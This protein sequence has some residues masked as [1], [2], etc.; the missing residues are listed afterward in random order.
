MAAELTIHIRDRSVAAAT[1]GS[2]ATAIRALPDPASALAPEQLAEALAEALSAGDA[3]RRAATLVIPSSWCYVHRVSVPRR[4]P[5]QQVL[6]YALEEFLPV[7]IE[8]L[9]CV[10]IPAAEGGHLGIAVETERLQ[11]LLEACGAHGIH[12]EHVTLD[13]L[14]AANRLP[15]TVNLL[16]CD[17]EHVALLRCAGRKPA[18]LRV[19]RIAPDL[20]EQEWCGRV[21]GH[22]RDVGIDDTQAVLVDGCVVG[23]W[24]DRLTELLGGERVAGHGAAERRG[25]GGLV[26]DLA[27]GGLVSERT[28]VRLLQ[29][30]RRAV[31]V[32]LVALLLI[33]GGLLV[34]RARL[35]S[36]LRAVAA[37][38]APGVRGALP[39][40]AA[41]RVV[42]PCAW[43]PSAADWR[44]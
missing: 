20:P 32:A 43:L 39:L 44:G 37:L 24:L 38:A 8:Q 18:D 33:A 16:W 31:T 13:V 9:T 30:W 19:F 15:Q 3:L 11:S 25:T 35:Q 36:E 4:R 27:C 42:S 28:R 2:A 22:L 23:D 10:F 6:A 7:D 21:E 1:N 26:C 41:P 29:A 17:E 34:Q 40:S 5:S 14:H 12:V